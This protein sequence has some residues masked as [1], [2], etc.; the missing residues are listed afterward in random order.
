[1]AKRKFYNSVLDRALAAYSYLPHHPGQGLIVDRILPRLEPPLNG[2]RSRTRYGVRFECDLADKVTREIYYYGFN[3]RDCRVLSRL[4]RPGQVVLDIGANIGYFSL[5]FAKWVGAAGAVH[6][7]EPFPETVL[8]LKRNLELNACLN[9]IVRIHELAI[10]DAVGSLSMA[11]P[12]QGNSGC[13]YLRTDGSRTIE[14]T[15]LDAFVQQE[16]LSRVDLIK[17]DIEGSEVA[18]LEGARE[19]IERF[20][21]VFMIEVNPSALQRFSKTSADLIGLLGKH[22]YRMSC[23]TPIGTLKPLSH[24]PV[25]GQEPNV[26]AFPIN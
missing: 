18:L 15:T 25:Y 14:V 12:D 21:P 20:R 22:R 9:S 8:R 10:S 2:L 3:C 7:F 16:R 1:M 4:V 13:N 11:V 24:L 19:T 26:F 6:A 17:I 5:L 23:A